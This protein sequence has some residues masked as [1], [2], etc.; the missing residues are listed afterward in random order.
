MLISKTNFI[1]TLVIFYNLKQT[2]T[3]AYSE[4][5]VNFKSSIVGENDCLQDCKRRKLNMSSSSV[6]MKYYLEKL[7]VP[8]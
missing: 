5:N 6:S 1:F 2:F 4:E 8:L 3:G 7:G